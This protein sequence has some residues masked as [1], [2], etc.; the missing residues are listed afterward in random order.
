MSTLLSRLIVPFVAASTFA[1]AATTEAP[2]ERASGTVVLVFVILF[3][4]MCV[5]IVWMSMQSSRKEKLAQE[6]AD[7][8]AQGGPV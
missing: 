4:G 6:A 8:A 1:Q 7:R 3:I 5:G 2:T